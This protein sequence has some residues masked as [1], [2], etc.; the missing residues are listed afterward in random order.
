MP[1]MDTDKTRQAVLQLGEQLRQRGERLALAE[2]CTGG[3]IAA[4]CTAVAGSSDWFDGGVVTYSNAAK[5]AE[6]GVSPSLLAAHGAVS[7]PVAE[8][9]VAGVLSR[10][11]AQWAAAVT[12]IAGPGGAVPGKPVGTVWLAWGRA[13]D[14][15]SERLQCQG[16]RDAVRD[17]TVNQALL[18]L[19]EATAVASGQPAVPSAMGRTLGS[20]LGSTSGTPAPQDA[21]L[22]GLT[23]LLTGRLDAA[24]ANTWR[25]ALREA[26][27]TVRWWTLDEARRAPAEVDVAVVA[28]PEPG[29]LQ[30]FPRLRLIQSLWAGVDRLLADTSLPADVPLA[31]M[32]EPMM[33]RAMTET[34]VWAVLSLHRGF[35]AYAQRQQAGQ[36]RQHSQT[37]AEDTPVAVL[38]AGVLG[39]S[40]GA[41]LAALGYPVSHWQRDGSPLEPLLARSRIVV[42]LLPLTPHTRGLFDRQRLAALPRGASL[43]NLARGAHVVDADLLQALDS[44]QLRH[45]VL[46]VFHQEPLPPEHPFWRHPK[47]TLLPHVAALTDLRSAAQQVAA[48]LLRLQRGEPLQHRVE[49]SRGY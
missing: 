11:R 49:R 9:M 35:F 38:G 15:R 16:D 31:R 21:P 17:E 45:A 20:T 5:T 41:A 13:G 27:P 24:E 3:L 23:A 2:S 25:E 12:G 34:A 33:T 47:V 7:Q 37:R 6:L 44:G 19:C 22:Q 29:S 46:D 30:G 26:M 1:T 8:A 48:N 10:G 40:A 43:V 42:N 4:A 14:I 18:R 32:V 36:W 39:H 28:N